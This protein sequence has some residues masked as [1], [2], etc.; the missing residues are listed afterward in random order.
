M[1]YGRRHIIVK[2]T[3]PVAAGRQVSSYEKVVR[4]SDTM[5]RGKSRRNVLSALCGSRVIQPVEVY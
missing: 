1:N 3:L 4:L 2:P 5:I